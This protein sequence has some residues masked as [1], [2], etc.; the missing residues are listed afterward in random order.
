[1]KARFYIFSSTRTYA[2]TTA[3]AADGGDVANARKE[4]RKKRN[5]RE[6]G[7]EKTTSTGKHVIVVIVRT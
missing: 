7:K 2:L 5:E 1:M 4:G 6:R 3:L